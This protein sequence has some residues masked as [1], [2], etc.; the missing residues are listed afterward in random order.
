M[1]LSNRVHLDLRTDDR[2]AEVTRLTALGASVLAERSAPGL[3]W[4]IMA[5]PECNEFCVGSHHG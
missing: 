4:T 2:A 5:D 1:A 3:W